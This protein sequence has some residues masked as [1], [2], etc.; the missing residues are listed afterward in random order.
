MR[1][2]SIKKEVNDE[3][4]LREE[5]RLKKEI[6]DKHKELFMPKRLGRLKYEEPELDLKLSDEITGNLRTLKVL[7]L[8]L[9]LSVFGSLIKIYLKK[10]SL[11]E[12]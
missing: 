5:K 12:I 2:K 11:K 8:K 7:N 1:I 9:I 4:K 10:F 3:E 6:E